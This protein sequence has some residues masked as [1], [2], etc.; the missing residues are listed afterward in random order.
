[1]VSHQVIS[2]LS[3]WNF[4]DNE[5]ERV[6]GEIFAPLY[7][8]V[9]APNPIFVAIWKAFFMVAVSFQLGYGVMAFDLKGFWKSIGFYNAMYWLPHLYVVG[10]WALIYGKVLRKSTFALKDAR[11]P[12][13]EDNK[14]Q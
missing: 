14:V 12:K 5:T 4:F 11:N 7:D 13:K 9:V 1:M 10:V 3:F 2:S 6:V 8:R